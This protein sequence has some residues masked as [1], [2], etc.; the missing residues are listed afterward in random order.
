MSKAE[1]R[2]AAVLLM[3]LS[4][5]QAD[6]LLA[7]LTPPEVEAVTAEMARVE[8]L[9]AVEQEAVILEFAEAEAARSDAR[10]VH[11]APT[12]AVTSLRKQT[13]ATH[14]DQPLAIRP[15]SFV[16]DVAPTPWPKRWRMSVRR[17]SRWWPRTCRRH[18]APS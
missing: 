5:E 11:D 1:L 17:R 16:H 12:A 15:F 13:P 14:A 4:E 18:T 7:R 10:R 6:R 2:K 8:T 3:T 9:E